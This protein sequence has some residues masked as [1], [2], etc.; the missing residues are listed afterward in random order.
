[1]PKYKIIKDSENPAEVVFEKT[2]HKTE[3]TLGDLDYNIRHNLNSRK[4]I[5]AQTNVEKAKMKNVEESNPEVLTM[6]PKTKI[7]VYI[8]ERARAIVEVGEQKLKELDESIQGDQEE[9]AE[10]T[11]QTG[12]MLITIGDKTISDPENIVKPK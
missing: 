7:A 4:E 12:K 2:S 10:I 8:Y 6:D 11:K 3:I 5:E 1:M 9:M